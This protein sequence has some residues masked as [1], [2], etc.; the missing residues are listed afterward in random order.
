MIRTR[1][2]VGHRRCGAGGRACAAAVEAGR[3]R[4]CLLTKLYPTLSHKP[5]R[6]QG[7]MCGRWPRRE[8]D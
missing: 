1:T 6:A 5:V 8:K 7:G 4:D 3:G 2:N